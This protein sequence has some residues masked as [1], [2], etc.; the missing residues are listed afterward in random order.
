MI[1]EQC[2]P[3]DL[4]TNTIFVE[5]ADIN[6]LIDLS[7]VI[8]T[9]VSSVSYIALIR[10]KPVVMLGYTQLKNK[11]CTYE[12]FQIDEIDSVLTQAVKEKSNDFMRQNFIRHFAQMK[13]YYSAENL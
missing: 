7:D 5:Q 13:K 4:P 12:A 9:V 3:A 1:I 10:E 2:N 6:D 11:E 8:V